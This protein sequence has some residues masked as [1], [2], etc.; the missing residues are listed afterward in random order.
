MTLF[1]G[2]PDLPDELVDELCAECNLDIEHCQCAEG[3]AAIEDPEDEG[4]EL[5]EDEGDELDD[6][7]DDDEDGPDAA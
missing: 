4:D 3:F 5:D 6:D 1:D 7:D 2:L